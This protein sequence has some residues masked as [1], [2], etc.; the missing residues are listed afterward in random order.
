[1]VL[2][3]EGSRRNQQF[4]GSIAQNNLSRPS[5]WAFPGQAGSAPRRLVLF[6]R[7]PALTR[8]PRPCTHPHTGPGAQSPS[9]LDP[10]PGPAPSPPAPRPAAS[11]SPGSRGSQEAS[12]HVFPRT[13]CGSPAMVSVPAGAVYTAG[14]PW[15]WGGRTDQPQPRCH[16][17]SQSLLHFAVSEVGVTAHIWGCRG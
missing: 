9:A 2:R 17:P 7:A 10:A 12:A 8:C 6:L 4:G 1:M 16:L 3:E 11:G 5:A 13:G 14:A 15:P